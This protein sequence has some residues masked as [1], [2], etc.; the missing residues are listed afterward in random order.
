MEL[1]FDVDRNIFAVENVKVGDFVLG[2]HLS[3]ESL[4]EVPALVVESAFVIR[5]GEVG[6]RRIILVQDPVELVRPMIQGFRKA[7]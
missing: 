6:G 4:G 2:S 5:C 1:F 7:R 3:R